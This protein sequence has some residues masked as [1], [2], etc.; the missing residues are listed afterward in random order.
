M[1]ALPTYSLNCCVEYVCNNFG[2]VIL[3]VAV[4]VPFIDDA[5]NV[6]ILINSC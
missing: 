5:N 2:E 1:D 6:A 3:V 4:N